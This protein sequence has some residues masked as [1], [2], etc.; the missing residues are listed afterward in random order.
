MCLLLKHL[1]AFGNSLKPEHTSPTPMPTGPW[2]SSN[3]GWPLWF[4][5]TAI[6]PAFPSSAIAHKDL[7]PGHRE[8]G[9][10]LPVHRTL[11]ASGELGRCLITLTSGLPEPLSPDWPEASSCC[12]L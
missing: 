3:G 7:T 10:S 11:E 5:A 8:Q 9:K 1:R 12:H 6:S 2:R 4:P